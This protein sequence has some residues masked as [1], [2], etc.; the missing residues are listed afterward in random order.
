MNC[1]PSV[2]VV[3]SGNTE[4]IPNLV[5]LD[6]SRLVLTFGSPTSGKAYMN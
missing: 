4:I 5:Y 6:I 1:Y 3:D 2:T